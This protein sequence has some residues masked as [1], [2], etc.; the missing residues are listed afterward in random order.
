MS[1]QLSL[2]EKLKSFR[3]KK[4]NTLQKKTD[5]HSQGDEAENIAYTFLLKQGLTLIER[6]FNMPAGEV[7]LIMRDKNDTETV[8]YTHLTLPTKRIV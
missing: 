1:Q 5:K 8:S 3:K 2:F 6:N 4:K 7:D